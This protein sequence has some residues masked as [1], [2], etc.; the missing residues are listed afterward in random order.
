M[1][2]KTDKIDYISQ[3]TH[4]QEHFLLKKVF[5]CMIPFYILGILATVSPWFYSIVPVHLTDI[6]LCSFYAE[7]QH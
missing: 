3:M 4:L 2:R 1:A 7:Q 6:C 5:F